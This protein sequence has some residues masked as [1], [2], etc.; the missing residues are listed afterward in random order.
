MAEGAPSS[1]ARGAPASVLPDPIRCPRCNA[2]LQIAVFPALFNEQTAGRTGERIVDASQASCFYHADRQAHVSCDGCGRFLCELC[3]LPMGDRHLCPS[4]LEHPNQANHS[5]TEVN[6]GSSGLLYDNIALSLAIFP[7]PFIYPTLLTAPLVLFLVL[8]FW[9][10]QVTP[11]PRS[12][13][14][15]VL[16]GVLAALQI[17]GWITG[18]VAL[19]LYFRS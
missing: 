14:R 10:R 13:W 18:V 11:V 12:R 6:A 1:T 9:K 4:C 2:S 8:W 7:V 16:A 17:A 19:V 5:A 15:F 3:D